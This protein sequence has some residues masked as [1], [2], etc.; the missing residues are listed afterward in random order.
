M[1]KLDLSCLT[2]STGVN[3]P[4]MLVLL[5]IKPY[6]PSVD[7]AISIKNM[8]AEIYLGHHDTDFLNDSLVKEFV[9]GE[10]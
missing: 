7:D 10:R 6:L 2:V 5:D 1:A 4:M 3:F 9:K 8:E